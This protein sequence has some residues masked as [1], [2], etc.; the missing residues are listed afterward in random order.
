MALRYGTSRTMVIV[1]VKVHLKSRS[2]WTYDATMEHDLS[3]GDL[4]RRTGVATSALRFYETRG[5][6]HATRSL[7]GQRQYA[8]STIRRVSFI[9]IAQQVGLSLDEIREALATLPDNRTPTG[10]DWH[11][12]SASWRPR[13]DAQI[14][15]LHAL[16]D[17]LDGCIGCGCLSLDS[18]QL[19]NPRDVAADRGSGPH[20]LLEDE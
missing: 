20:Y 9:R 2:S 14:A 6:I 4:G 18:C 19:L 16:R 5:L 10:Q 11:A 15:L 12:L 1:E 7:G 3:I 13:I 17:R 8:R